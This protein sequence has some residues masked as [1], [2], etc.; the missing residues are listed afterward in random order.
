MTTNSPTTGKAGKKDSAASP[1]AGK[2]KCK[3]V[4]SGG[5]RGS[6]GK[7]EEARDLSTVGRSRVLV[8]KRKGP[9]GNWRPVQTKFAAAPSSASVQPGA[10]EKNSRGSQFRKH[11]GGSQWRGGGRQ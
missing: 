10:S 5:R 8:K 7:K 3:R 1:A 9:L 11:Q 2:V 6:W 4:V